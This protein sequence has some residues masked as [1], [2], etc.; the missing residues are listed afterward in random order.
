[1]T[2]PKSEPSK[3]YCNKCGYVGPHQ[4]GHFKPYAP[5]GQECNYMAVPLPAPAR[6]QPNDEFERG[7]QQGMKQ[8][9]ALWQLAAE[10]QKIEAQPDP[11]SALI[12]QAGKE[13]CNVAT[14]KNSLCRQT[15]RCHFEHYSAQPTPDAGRGVPVAWLW[16]L[17]GS[18]PQ[19]LRVVTE[20]AGRGLTHAFPVYTAP[21]TLTDAQCD[22]IR[23]EERRKVLLDLWDS[24]PDHETQSAP[25]VLD[26]GGP[27]GSLRATL[28][29]S[30]VGD[31][32][33]AK[34]RAIRAAA[35]SGG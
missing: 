28:L 11:P 2:D 29:L 33:K 25:G 31:E 4:S 21:P 20:A 19:E 1:M 10:G 16:P 6:P 34:E 7:R 35:R 12:V 8:E 5:T 24:L 32:I 27:F 26:V 23:E 15:N 3:F 22:S 30:E 18:K 9:R 17:P 13:L 14:C